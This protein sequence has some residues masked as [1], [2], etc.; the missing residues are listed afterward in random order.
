MNRREFIE[1]L[2]GFGLPRGEY[3]ILSGGSLLLRGLREET[4][5]FDLAVSKSLAER[6]ALSACPKDAG[7]CYS[8]F[9]RVQ[10]TD[11]MEDRPFDA[12][13]G[14]LCQTLESVLALKRRLRRPK[15]LRDI[16]VI[17]AR[18]AAERG[19][20]LRIREAAP[21][22]AVLA[23]LIRFSEEWAAENSCH[24]YR[25]NERADIEGNRIF[26]AHAGSRT[27]GYLF[28]K[29]CVSRNMTSI[30]PEGTPYFEVEELYVIP[31]RRS[32]GVGKA[33]FRYAE[34]AVAGEA[35]FLL[36]STAVKNWRAVFHFYL[37]ELEM[38]FWSARLYKKIEK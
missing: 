24:G 36:L 27:V 35:D 13:D 10:M 28:G 26:L 18:L 38:E 16:P 2:E 14:F 12:V 19:E 4:E 7:G 3:V 30:M 11:N 31:D 5:D 25:A 32:R 37:D 33:L 21:D 34:E 17:E 1:E 23:L 20:A 29:A 9:P 6:L 15:D 8:P 22:E